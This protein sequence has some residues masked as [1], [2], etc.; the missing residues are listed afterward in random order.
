MLFQS[1]HFIK[2]F[3]S[4]SYEISKPI[5][6]IFNIV[7]IFLLNSV[8]K[9]HIQHFFPVSNVKFRNRQSKL[10]EFFFCAEPT[11]VSFIPV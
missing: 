1:F 10:L 2:L 4:V 7:L 3:L 8:R 9:R 5:M 6:Q 11:W